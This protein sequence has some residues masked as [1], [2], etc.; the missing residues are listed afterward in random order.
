MKKDQ[1]WRLQTSG[2]DCQPQHARYTASGGWVGADVMSSN[3]GDTA[4][5]S[6]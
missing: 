3:V 1:A 4:V 6:S 5:Q 2:G